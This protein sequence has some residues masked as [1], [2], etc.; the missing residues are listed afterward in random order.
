MSNLYDKASLIVTPNAYKA[1]KIYSAKPTDGSGDLVFSR[2]STATRRNSSGFWES[3]ASGV[4]RLHYPVGGGCPAWLMEPA[5]TNKS[6]Y[7]NDVSNATWGKAGC[8]ITYAAST[9]FKNL[10][11]ANVVCNSNVIAKQLTSD[12]TGN[13]VVSVV[14]KKTDA[15]IV[16]IDIP[17]G[18]ATGSAGRFWFTFSTE[19]ITQGTGTTTLVDKTN[20]NYRFQCV[21]NVTGAGTHVIYIY[22]T[23][24][25]ASVA[26]DA[27]KG[28]IVNY[29][30][31]ETGSVATSPI[32]T[33]GSAVTRLADNV[34][35]TGASDP[36]GQ[37]EGTIFVDV[38]INS[39]NNPSANIINGAKNTNSSFVILRVKAT[40]A[41]R[42]F[43]YN[44]TA[45]K[46]DIT[47][48]SYN[49]GDRLKIAYAYKSGDSALYVNGTQLGTSA[50]TISFPATLSELNWDDATT[51]FGYQ[52][53][54]NINESRISK[55][56]LPN[57]ELAALTT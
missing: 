29:A 23:P 2:A 37:T 48:G 51:Y 10:N 19:T 17:N 55:T 34:N 6:I 28:M 13:W 31:F 5:A 15:D 12:S 56:R 57:A 9:Y 47:G 54:E 25:N 16:L 32:I 8:T 36:I 22:P 35:K 44:S 27:N 3:V 50:D 52:E 11:E 49:L 24:T 14:I 43:I 20:G 45:L 30:G 46:A 41:I 53:A 1:S 26:L 4:P 33:A 39:E 42:A 40:K 21:I 38:V 7:S 18:S